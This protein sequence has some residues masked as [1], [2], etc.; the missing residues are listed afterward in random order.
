MKKSDYSRHMLMMRPDMDECLE[1]TKEAPGQA[2]NWYELGMAY[3]HAGC[4]QASIDAFSQGIYLDPFNPFMHFSRGRK[5][6]ATGQYWRGMSDLRF[7]L[8][9]MPDNWVFWY[10]CATSN[11]L[12]GRYEESIEDFMKCIEFTEPGERY[13]FI[14]WI[15]TTY[16]LDLGDKAKAKEALNLIPSKEFQPP[17]MDYGYV[18]NVMLYSGQVSPQDFVDLEEMNEKCLGTDNRVNLELNGMYYG[19]F[20]YAVYMEDQ[21]LQKEALENL[22]KVKVEGAFGYTRGLVH[23]KKLGLTDEKAG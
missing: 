17:Q 8:R 23:A 15:Y 19:L 14:H 3:M 9:L 6:S 1:K 20:A 16:L 12:T 2:M 13:P 5:L 21:A 4:D 10:Y 11:N 18:R 22:L 7:A